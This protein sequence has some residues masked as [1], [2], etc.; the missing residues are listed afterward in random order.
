MLYYPKSLHKVSFQSS[1]FCLTSQVYYQQ[2]HSLLTIT[3]DQFVEGGRG[4]KGKGDRVEAWESE[5]WRQ[6]VGE[7]GLPESQGLQ[8]GPCNRKHCSCVFCTERCRL[9]TGSR[10]QRAPGVPG[11]GLEVRH[12]ISVVLHVLHQLPAGSKIY[13]VSSMSMYSTVL[14]LLLRKMSQIQ[15]QGRSKGHSRVHAERK[16]RGCPTRKVTMLISTSSR[17]AKRWLCFYQQGQMA[18]EAKQYL[19]Q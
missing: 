10:G 13:C 2:I 4:V 5:T 1:I 8:S 11:T 9:E 18:A 12:L 15:K 19:L 14:Q 3:R 7:R 16:K 17:D 6:G